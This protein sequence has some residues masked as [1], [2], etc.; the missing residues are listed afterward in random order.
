MGGGDY[1]GGRGGRWLS[2]SFNCAE[3]LWSC[4]SDFHAPT[5]PNTL[6]TAWFFPASRKPARSTA[7]DS[8][9]SDFAIS[10]SDSGVFSPRLMRSVF[11][12]PFA[13]PIQPLSLPAL[14]AVNIQQGSS[15]EWNGRYSRYA[16]SA[17]RAGLAIRGHA[18]TVAHA[19]SHRVLRAR[20][21]SVAKRKRAQKA[22]KSIAHN[23]DLVLN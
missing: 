10:S 4:L 3:N 12:F 17:Q 15:R 13:L 22:H 11:D 20:N 2:S 9:L 6:T 5:V 19:E 7:V 18:Q 16:K 23:V 8:A 1:S 14:T 21:V